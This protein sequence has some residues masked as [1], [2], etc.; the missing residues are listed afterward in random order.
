MSRTV[1]LV[2][3]ATTVAALAGCDGVVGAKMTFDDI[4]K[5]KVSDI[6]LTGGSGDVTVTTGTVTETRIK[7]VVRGGNGSGPAYQL[8]GTTLTL[9]TDCGFDC[10]ISYEIQAPAGVKVRGDQRSGRVDLTGVGAVDLTLTSG[11]V[12]IDGASAP[13][14]IKATSGNVSVIGAPGVTMEATSGDLEAHEITGPVTAKV[15]SGNL[16]LD[17]AAPA[18]VTASVTSGDLTLLVPPGKYR[19]NQHTAS[20]DA[21]ID[22]VTSDP[23]APNVLDLRARSGNL[24]V[25]AL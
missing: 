1:A 23:D 10:S 11:D 12:S 16:D 18:S 7:R 25:S 3:A 20:G 4:E 24:T 9:P 19:I 8:S 17:L 21:E 6:V 14:K 22:G 5:T 15:T 13:V 2:L